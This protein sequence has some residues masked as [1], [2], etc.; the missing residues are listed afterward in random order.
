MEREESYPVDEIYN[1]SRNSNHLRKATQRPKSC[2]Y[3]NKDEVNS[4]NNVNI[5]IL[6]IFLC[7]VRVQLISTHH[8]FPIFTSD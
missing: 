8:I 6:V 2:Q 7:Q 1:S 4:P 5:V 3:D